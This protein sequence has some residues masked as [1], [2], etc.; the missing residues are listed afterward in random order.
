M[1][2]KKANTMVFLKKVSSLIKISALFLLLVQA[3]T[4]RAKAPN[5]PKQKK[6]Y[7]VLFI[8]SEI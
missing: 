6:K 5:D 7:N 8:A 1:K 2:N 4:I 3:G